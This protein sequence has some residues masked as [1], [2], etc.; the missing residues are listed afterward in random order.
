MTTY[1]V[2]WEIDVEAKDPVDAARQARKAQHPDTE[3]LV[4]NCKAKGQKPVLIDLMEV[5]DEL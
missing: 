4:F 2:I 1:K 3:V 5:A